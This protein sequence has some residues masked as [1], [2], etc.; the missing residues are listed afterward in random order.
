MDCFNNKYYKNKLNKKKEDESYHQ[1][2]DPFFQGIS[3][4]FYAG[5]D[6]HPHDQQYVELCAHQMDHDPKK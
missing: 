1:Q 5:H 3:L 2:K 4:F 6:I